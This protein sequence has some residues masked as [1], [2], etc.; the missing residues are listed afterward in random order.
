MRMP[1]A[2]DLQSLWPV[3]QAF[4]SL[5]IVFY[6]GGSVASNVYGRWRTTMDTDLV[7]T[8]REEHVMPLVIRLSETYYIDAEMI[9]EAIRN[10]ASFNLIHNDTA[11]KVDV[12]VSKG[13]PYDLAAAQRAEHRPV[14]EDGRFKLPVASPEDV[15]LSKL[16]WYRLGD[17]ASGRQWRDIVDV[18]KVQSTRLDRTYLAR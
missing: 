14:S 1:D 10:R 6:V 15:I 2:A 8:L 11:Q 3:A 18:I 5:G 17:E 13:R 4:E 7:A 16:E 12:F 9:R